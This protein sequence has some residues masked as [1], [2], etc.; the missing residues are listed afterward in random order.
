MPI[1]LILLLLSICVGIVAVNAS[2]QISNG[3]VEIGHGS[4]VAQLV[5]VRERRG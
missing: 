1:L 3:V 2:C 5:L 4:V